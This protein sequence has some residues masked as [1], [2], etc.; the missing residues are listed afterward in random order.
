MFDFGEY[1]NSLIDD[2]VKELKK[3]EKQ[4]E[5]KNISVKRYFWYGL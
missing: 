2:L 5:S 4:D 1:F 3:K